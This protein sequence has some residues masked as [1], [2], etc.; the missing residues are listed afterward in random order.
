M[1]QM[2]S[3]FHKDTFEH[4]FFVAYFF[5]NAVGKAAVRLFTLHNAASI[6]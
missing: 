6:T 4:F 3:Y 2:V 5:A 1:E